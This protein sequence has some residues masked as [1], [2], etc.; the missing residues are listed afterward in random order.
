MS[1]ITEQRQTGYVT[2]GRFM[3][4]VTKDEAIRSRRLAIQSLRA[5]SRRDHRAYM[6]QAIRAWR[7]HKYYV[8]RMA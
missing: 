4:D 8:R 3:A 5:G 1:V 2:S 6:H 7:N